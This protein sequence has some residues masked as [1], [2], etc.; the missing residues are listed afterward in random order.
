MTDHALTIAYLCATPRMLREMTRDCTA[1]QVTTPSKPGEW[2][3]VDVVRHLVEGDRDTFLPRLRRMLAEDRPVFSVRRP[4]ENDASDLTTLLDVFDRARAE[5]VKILGGLDATAWSREGVSPSRGP[6]SVE[7]YAASTATHDTEHLR[8]IQDVRATL[9]LAPKR[10]EARVALSTTEL[11]TALAATPR[12]IAQLA[13]GLD[14]AAL[15]TRPREGEWSLTE[16]MAHLCDLDR[17]LF[18]PRLRRIVAE[19]RP[20]FE[21][22]DPQAWERERDHRAREFAADLAGFAGA[23]A[24]TVAFLQRLPAGAAERLG[25]SGHFGPMTLAQYATHVLDHDLEHLGQ[26]RDCGAALPRRG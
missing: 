14:A 11:A 26:M 24:E 20:A 6:L 25:V 9:G 13:D 12:R 7:A 19:A 1:A 5:V 4:L 22:F 16:V 15:R 2:S 18:L 10:C 17:V 8:Q 3:I 23:R 21:A